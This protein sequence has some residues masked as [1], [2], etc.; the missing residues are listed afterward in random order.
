VQEIYNNEVLKP[1]D[2]KLIIN[3]ELIETQNTKTSFNP[4][5]L[6]S[7]GDVYLA[8]SEECQKAIQAAKNA[9]PVWKALPAAERGRI[10]KRAKQILLQ[11]KD[12]IARLISIEKGSP[13]AE[14]HSV[15]VL[16]SLEAL[17]YYSQKSKDPLKAKKAKHSVIL[18]LHKKSSFQFQPLGPTLIISPWNFPFL[19]PIYDIMSALAAGNTVVLRPSTTTP[20]TALMIGKIFLEAELP[21]GVLNIINCKVEQAEQMITNPDIQNVMFTGSTE[22]GKRIMELSSRNLTNTVL[23]LGGKDP[24]LV[25][26]DAD[27]ERA[28]RG[29]VWAAFMN[30]G[31]SCGSIERAYVAEEISAEFTERVLELTKQLK[32]GDPLESGI[33][34]GP[35]AS[36]GQL[37][38][39]KDHIEDARLKGAHVLYGGEKPRDYTGYFIMPTVLTG[40]NH[41]MKIMSEETF[42]PVL[43]IMTFSSLNEAAALANDT[44]FGLTA[45][46]WTKNKKLASRLAERLDAGS[47]TI[48]DHMFSFVEPGAIWGGIKGTGIGRSHGP[49]GSLNL[50]NIKYVSHDFHKKKTQLWWFPYDQKFPQLLDRALTLFHHDCIKDKVKTLPFLLSSLTR[51]K[52]GSPLSNF[53]KGIPRILKK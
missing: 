50:V 4:A 25:L 32:V 29:A 11:K 19:I 13:L 5:T 24:M 28:S 41:T 8:S 2:G 9:F 12:E 17:D 21:E 47:I 26:E 42:G 27:L 43:P 22:T 37:Q 46:I 45:S 51:I 38:T 10:F 15:E 34:I 53:V 23:E 44:P 30:C 3:N 16:G 14:S 49:Y 31:Q 18:F 40:V 48:N 33:D 1:M 20:F 39:V 6:K 35:M 52:T 7:L 36:I